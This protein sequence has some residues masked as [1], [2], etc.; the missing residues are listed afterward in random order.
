MA[1][2]ELRLVRRSAEFI[3]K[4]DVKLLPRMLRGIYV[5]YKMSRNRGRD[6]YDVLYVGMAAAGRR[7]GMRGRLMSHARSKR[8]GKLWTHFS[9][10]EVWD[11]IRDEEVTELE[12]LFRHIYRKDSAANAL[13]VQRGFKKARR[14]RQNDLK[15]WRL[16]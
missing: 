11:N 3:R 16:S 2:S 5:L 14:V 8:K 10:F 12:G 1:E 4:D 9:A 15:K 7:G 6:K 13:N